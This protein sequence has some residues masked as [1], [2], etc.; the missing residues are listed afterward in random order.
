MDE[1]IIPNTDN[2]NTC[3]HL[4]FEVDSGTAMAIPAPE[5]FCHRLNPPRCPIS[6]HQRMYCLSANYNTCPV[7]TQ[8]LGSKAVPKNI[9][10]RRK[11]SLPPI[12]ARHIFLALLLA[13]AGVLVAMLYTGLIRLP[14]LPI[15]KPT[16]TVVTNTPVL[17]VLLPTLTPTPVFTPTVTRTPLPPTLTPTPILPLLLETPVS[18]LGREFIIH[19][20]LPGEALLLLADMYYTSSEAIRA[21]NYQ[22]PATIWE[23]MLVVI[24]YMHKNV[25]AVPPMTVYQVTEEKMTMETLARQLDLDALD[26]S[27]LLE[28]NGRPAGYTLQ[29]GEYILIP[30]PLALTPT[31]LP[32][33]TPYP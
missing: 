3:P 33:Q 21:V 29:V 32:W 24:P 7:Y 4:G 16:A 30:Y 28:V 10:Y 25:F 5:N 14:A 23:G 31:L 8:E 20:T 15:Q 12:K 26:A 18:P 9:F 13:C 17:E 6:V 27:L 19:K 11:R 1:S 22:M 2:E